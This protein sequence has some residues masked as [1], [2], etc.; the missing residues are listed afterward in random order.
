MKHRWPKSIHS[1]CEAILHGIRAIGVKKDLAPLEIRSFG[2]WNRYRREFHGLIDD[3]RKVGGTDLLDTDHLSQSIE[4]SLRYRLEYHVKNGHSRQTFEAYQAAISKFEYAY[5]HYVEQHSLAAGQLDLTGLRKSLST[6]ARQNLPKSSRSF[7]NRAYPDPLSLLNAV[8][9]PIYQLQAT[10]QYEGGFRAEGVGSPG[11][12]LRNPLTKNSLRGFCADPVTQKQVGI[13][14]SV[15]KGGKETD[16][17]ISVKT[18]ERLQH[19]IEGHELL[20]SRYSAYIRAIN[21]AAKKTG[22]FSYG[23]GTHGLKHN[24]A[25]ER[26]LECVEYGYR[27]EEALQQVSLETG[28]F[29]LKETLTYTRG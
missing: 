26:Y 3:F 13:V 11:N 12:G 28:H 21:A 9:N 25:Q 17:Y 5:N 7:F 15:E 23:R 4:M 18:Y 27:H 1:Q 8:D 19:Y 2:V 16:H 24:F 6:A 20:E 14:A 10:L 22:Q 29:R